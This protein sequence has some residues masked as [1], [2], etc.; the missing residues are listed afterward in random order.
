MKTK[1]TCPEC[2]KI[3]KETSSSE[4]FDAKCPHCG[5]EVSIAAD[6]AMAERVI[7]EAEKKEQA[8]KKEADQKAKEEAR[9]AALRKLE[10]EN[11]KAVALVGRSVKRIC[12]H[13]NLEGTWQVNAKPGV[14][15]FVVRCNGYGCR[16]VFTI[17]NSSDELVTPLAD[18]LRELEVIRY[19]FGVLLFCLFVLPF[20]IWIILAIMHAG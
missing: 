14:E 15:S 3:F 8:E 1:Y 2:Q 7:M 20:I 12:P 18:I 16:K 10:E 13:C 6:P 17:L 11:A 5:A 19:R 4:G 9:Q